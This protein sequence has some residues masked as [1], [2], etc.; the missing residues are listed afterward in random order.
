MTIIKN[1]FNIATKHILEDNLDVLKEEYNGKKVVLVYDLDSKL[2]REL[3]KAYINNLEFI[4]NS[5]VIDFNEINKEE[6]K[7]LLLGLEEKSCV[8]LVQSTN[9]RL[10][11][12]RIRMNLHNRW[13][14][15]LEH[16]HLWY[17]K[18]NQVETYADAIEYNTP[19]YIRL[20]WELKKLVDN[21]E[22]IKV[23]CNDWSTFNISG[24]FEDMKQNSGDYTW[25]KRGGTFPVWE[26]FTESKNFDLVNWEVSIYAIPDETFQVEFH[27]PFKIKIE[28]SRIIWDNSAY[29]ES[30]KNIMEKIKQSEDNEVMVRELW[31]GFNEW[32]T[33]E[34]PLSDINAFERICWFHMSIWKKHQIYRKKIHKSIPQRYHIDIF[35]DIEEIWVD[36]VVVFEGGKYVI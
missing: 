2:S 34:K 33:R 25:K 10:D 21:A 19:N 1:K 3:S 28:K 6:L 13:I 27:K 14:W 29:P 9:F 22:T 5:D 8:I 32:I 24:W 11:D 7:E 20:W 17:I 12:F 35:P 31:F 23:I 4:E 18:D 30:F 16:N 36:D 26:N 15:C